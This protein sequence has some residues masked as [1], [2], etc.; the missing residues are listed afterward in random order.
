MLLKKIMEIGLGGFAPNVKVGVQK[1][2]K[3]IK[4]WMLKKL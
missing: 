4:A 3:G 2:K 1:I